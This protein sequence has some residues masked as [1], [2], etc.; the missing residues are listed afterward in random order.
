[1]IA[2]HIT[3]YSSRNSATPLNLSLA[4]LESA[5]KRLEKYN[6]PQKLDKGIR[7][8]LACHIK[9]ERQYGKDHSENPR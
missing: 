9:K 5:G 3:K 6:T 4:A 1:M 2:I 7:W 8:M